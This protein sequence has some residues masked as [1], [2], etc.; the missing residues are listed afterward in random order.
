MPYIKLTEPGSSETFLLQ[1]VELDT[2]GNWPDYKLHAANGDIIIGPKAALDRQLP[3]LKAGAMEDLIGSYI[4][5]SRSEKVGA[6]GKPFWNLSVSSGAEAKAQ[7]PSSKR[8]APPSAA[9]AK[10]RTGLPP[11]EDETP[12]PTDR[13]APESVSAVASKAKRTDFPFGANVAAL[14]A[15]AAPAVAT[16]AVHDIVLQYTSL[17]AQ[18]AEQLGCAVTEPV[19]QSATATI[20]ISLSKGGSR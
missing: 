8:V 6:N 17:M 13:D 12:W 7:V 20:W 11:E 5:V 16:S 4:T 10:A 14:V 9:E 1:Q 3:N 2:K 19:V 15:P 18:V